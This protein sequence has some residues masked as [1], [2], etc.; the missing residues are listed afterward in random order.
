MCL[1]VG[2]T[3]VVLVELVE[4]ALDGRAALV[5]SVIT[6]VSILLSVRIDLAGCFLH[7]SLD[8]RVFDE[9]VA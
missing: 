6:P 4:M 3:L 1:L 8:H 7:H 2:F 9:L 5:I